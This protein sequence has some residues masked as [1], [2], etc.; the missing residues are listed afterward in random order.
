MIW[1][2]E[3]KGFESYLK[4][5][6]SLSANSVA[7][8]RRDVEK[9]ADYMEEEQVKSVSSVSHDHL[10]KFIHHLAKS[11]I[12]A[13][14]QARMVS[15]IRAFFKYLLMEKLIQEDP[16]E[17]LELPKLGSKLP[18]VLSINEVEEIL[19]SIDMSRASGH[20]DR[21]MLEVLYGCGLRVSELSELLI[22]NLHLDEGFIKV[23]GKGDKERLVPVGGKALQHISVYRDSVRNKEDA[24][25][26]FE[27]HL[28]L[29]KFGRKL[30]RVSIFNLVKD[31][32]ARCGIKKNV[33]PHTFRHSF[34]THLV[35]GGADLRAVQ[36]M[37][38]HESITTTE[39]YSH[40]DRDYLKASI[41]E[42]HPLERAKS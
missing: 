2:P 3:I 26:G 27:D 39:I 20:R 12:K 5:E 24:A 31:C 11:G 6:R 30:S 18:V 4:L 7:A 13:R 41:M 15:G 36:E 14:S 19:A 28:F 35:H 42:F 34:A 22:S 9:L 16:S 32:C 37:L 8:Y 25:K 33:S 40:L 1:R 10:L 21:T 17:L 23:I 38:G 29:N